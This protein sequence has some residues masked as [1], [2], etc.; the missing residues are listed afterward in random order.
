MQIDYLTFILYHYAMNVRDMKIPNANSN[1]YHFPD[2]KSY[3][4]YLI[5]PHQCI[6]PLNS[7]KSSYFA[8]SAPKDDCVGAIN[9]SNPRIISRHR[10]IEILKDFWSVN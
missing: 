10:S 5:V 2:E 7:Y 1:P 6:L 8:Y 4:P 9:S 3:V